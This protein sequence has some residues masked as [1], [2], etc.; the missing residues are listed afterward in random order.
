MPPTPG[1]SP[2]EPGRPSPAVLMELFEGDT[3]VDPL[4]GRTLVAALQAVQPPGA[5]PVLLRRESGVGHS[6]RSLERT[7]G[8]AVDSLA[9]LA[10]HLG[11][12]CEHPRAR[13][14]HRADSAR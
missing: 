14:E 6:T 4:H 9:F 3:R 5:V 12:D 11:L 8:L 1:P 13:D 7:V 2:G 10:H